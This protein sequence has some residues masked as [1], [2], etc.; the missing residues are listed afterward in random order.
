MVHQGGTR[1]AENTDKCTIRTVQLDELLSAAKGFSSAAQNTG[2]T[3]GSPYRAVQLTRLNIP[4]EDTNAAQEACANKAVVDS[5][6]LLAAQP[7]SERAFAFACTTLN[8][9]IISVDLSKRLSIRF[10]PELI[11]AAVNRGVYFEITYAAALR[12]G[13][14]RRQLFTN[15]QALTRATRGRNVVISSGANSMH[16]LRGAHDVINLG[17]FLGLTEQQAQDSVS[18]N[19]VAVVEHAR[20]RKAYRATLTLRVGVITCFSCFLS[21]EHEIN[22]RSRALLVCRCWSQEKTCPAQLSR[23]QRQWI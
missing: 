2:C 3:V 16:E 5:Y 4:V 9:D 6:D 12:E 14:L 7:E 17:T 23:R 20:R 8:V 1:L 11:K 10:K 21:A 13:G 22:L 19:A 15:A 18:K